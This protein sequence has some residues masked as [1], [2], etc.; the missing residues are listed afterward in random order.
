MSKCHFTTE[1]VQPGF[2]TG[3]VPRDFLHRECFAPH[4]V[5]GSW[6]ADK[7]NCYFLKHS[8]KFSCES[9]YFLNSSTSKNIVA[10]ELL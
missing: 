2:L 1:V 4:T 9:S 3:G 7:L 8:E 10:G 6:T 5:Y